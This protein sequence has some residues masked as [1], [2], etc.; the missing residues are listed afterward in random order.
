VIVDGVKYRRERAS[1][2]MGAPGWGKNNKTIRK[3]FG[4]A[5]LRL[6]IEDWWFTLELFSAE[7]IIDRADHTVA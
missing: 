2:D 4:M 7:K 3:L 5:D 6:L 1:E